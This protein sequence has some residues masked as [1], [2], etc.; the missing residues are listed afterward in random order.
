M[1]DKEFKR[2]TLIRLKKEFSENDTI[3]LLS[4][5]LSEIETELGIV[6][7]ERDE[8]IYL[9]ELE[10]KSRKI[11]ESRQY[12][13]DGKINEIRTLKMEKKELNIEIKYL[14]DKLYS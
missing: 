5:K 3:N 9:L 13:Y 6:K 2:E 12:D 8:A 7:S 1:K 11:A 4:K 14:T 10:K